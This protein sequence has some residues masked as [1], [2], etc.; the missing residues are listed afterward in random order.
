MIFVPFI[1]V[2]ICVLL[3]L[4]FKLSTLQHHHLISLQ[5]QHLNFRTSEVPGRIPGQCKSSDPRQIHTQ[6]R[7]SI[8]NCILFRSFAM[9][10]FC[11]ASRGRQWFLYLEFMCCQVESHLQWEHLRFLRSHRTLMYVAYKWLYQL[12]RIMAVNLDRG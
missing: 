11:T 7:V 3:V 8:K 6:R 1:K 9:I 5:R 10:S 2:H 4:A 12:V